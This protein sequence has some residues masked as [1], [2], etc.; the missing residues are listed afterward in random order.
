MVSLF[1]ARMHVDDLNDR[2]TAT[3]KITNPDIKFVWV[4]FRDSRIL[5]VHVSP[6]EA[7]DAI[8]RL[9]QEFLVA[10][11]VEPE[12]EPEPKEGAEAKPMSDE[13][14]AIQKFLK[15]KM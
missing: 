15:A 1:V 12:P 11:E 3:L 9:E 10:T 4:I 8:V 7:A 2:F 6:Q 14:S 13:E 5:E